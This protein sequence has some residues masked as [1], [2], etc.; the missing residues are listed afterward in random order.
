MAGAGSAP[1]GARLELDWSWSK[2][3]GDGSASLGTRPE[4]FRI[5]WS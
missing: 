4:L 5:G 1:L 2:I 3:G